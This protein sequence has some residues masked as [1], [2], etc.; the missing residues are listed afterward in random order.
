MNQ[1]VGKRYLDSPTETVSVN[2][3]DFAYR[4]TGERS[5]TPVILFNHLAGVLDDW[6][7]MVVDGIAERLRSSL[8]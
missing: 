4:M 5:G 7:P 2:G 6:D 1:Q 3:T 8:G